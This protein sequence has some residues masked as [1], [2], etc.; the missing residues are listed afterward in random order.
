MSTVLKIF[1][2]EALGSF[3]RFF[4]KMEAKLWKCK[5]GN[6]QREESN[7]HQ[8]QIITLQIPYINLYAQK[9]N[10]IYLIL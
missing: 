6:K 8:A 2:V 9:S 1:L 10:K 3:F 5:K 4:L 7:S